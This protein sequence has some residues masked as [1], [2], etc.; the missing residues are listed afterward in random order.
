MNFHLMIWSTEFYFQCFAV[1]LEEPS[2][3]KTEFFFFLR[4]CCTACG[5]LESLP[6]ELGAQSLDHW[7]TGSSFKKK[8]RTF[9]SLAFPGYSS[10]MFISLL[11]LYTLVYSSNNFPSYIAQRTTNQQM[12]RAV[13]ILG[14]PE[15]SVI[16]LMKEGLT[17]S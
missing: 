11:F 4:P 17:N 12:P 1:I 5:N 7:T 8:H 3:R 15:W 13:S 6:P 16:N 14:C 9:A 10:S 2:R